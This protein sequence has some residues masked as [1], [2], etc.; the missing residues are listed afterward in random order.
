MRVIIVILFL[1]VS[2]GLFANWLIDYDLTST[3]D[4]NV[5]TLSDADLDNF[6]NKDSSLTFVKT[7]DDLIL[8]NS[9]RL[10]YSTKI[11]K[12]KIAPYTRF[13]YESYVKNS[14][15][16]NYSFYNGIGLNYRKVVLN[17]EYLYSADNY[18]REYKDLDGSLKQEKYE[19]DK[20]QFK[21]DVNYNMT[22]YDDFG[23]TFKHESYYYNKYFTEYDAS[24]LS[25]AGFYKHEFSLFEVKGG[26]TYK[27]L[28]TDSN[29]NTFN[30]IQ[31]KLSNG[32][33]DSNRY[34]LSL[35]LSEIKVYKRIQVRPYF[36]YSFDHKYYSTDL[37]VYVD[38]THS[39]RQDKTT[40]YNFGKII[41]INK[42][43][44]IVLDYCFE[45]RKVTS[46][47]EKLKDYKDY[48]LNQL[49]MKISYQLAL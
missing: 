12:V 39:S 6:E 13:Q 14:D 11:N 18:T 25:Y 4:D 26:Y 49:M 43:V 9:L 19:Y 8:N 38:A 28:I 41:K 16:N 20:D 5:F 27:K 21:L 46:E 42:S 40:N 31:D 34:D 29:V 2:G 37:P 33:Y 23:F 45:K 3:W 36:K 48:K 22:R 15:K 1:A 32:S 35:T 24:A 30:N 44:D 47:N 7:T 10:K 17:F